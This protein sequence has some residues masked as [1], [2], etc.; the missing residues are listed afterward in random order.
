MLLPSTNSGAIALAIVGKFI[1]RFINLWFI[2]IYHMQLGRHTQ[3]SKS[4]QEPAQAGRAM[5][6]YLE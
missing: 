6:Y 5:Q 4:R 3:K 2:H 1:H